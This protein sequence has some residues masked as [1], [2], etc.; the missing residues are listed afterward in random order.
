MLPHFLSHGSG[1]A[2]VIHPFCEK[3]HQGTRE[4]TNMPISCMIAMHKHLELKNIQTLQPNSNTNPKNFWS[5]SAHREKTGNDKMMGDKVKGQWETRSNGR[6]TKQ[7]G[8]Q[9]TLYS[10]R[11]FRRSN[12]RLY[13]KLPLGLAASMFDSRDVLQHRCETWKILAG[14]NYAKWCVFTKFRG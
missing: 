8:K 2:S 9:K 13:W 14:R 4:N 3:A 6:E 5:C 10:Q 12:F 1:P 7:R 11:K